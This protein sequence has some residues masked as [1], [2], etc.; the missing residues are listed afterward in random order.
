MRVVPIAAVLAPL[1][2]SFA[3]KVG[4]RLAAKAAKAIMAGGTSGPSP[5]ATASAASTGSP[6]GGSPSGGLPPGQTFAATLKDEEAR[7]PVT[8][9]PVSAAPAPPA[10]APLPL[11]QVAYQQGVRSLALG[12]QAR[13]RMGWPEAPRPGSH[14][15]PAH[16]RPP[17]ATV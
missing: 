8:A 10:G 15:A 14:F 17:S 16:R 12:A 6:S 3:V 9:V 1:A 4:V 7:L 2:L 5:T 11:G 13:A